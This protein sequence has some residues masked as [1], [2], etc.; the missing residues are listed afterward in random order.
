M[1]TQSARSGGSVVAR[2]TEPSA[3]NAFHGGVPFAREDV[4]RAIDPDPAR[5]EAEEDAPLVPLDEEV[6][7]VA[8]AAESQRGDAIVG[9]LFEAHDG[10]RIV[11][12]QSGVSSHGQGTY[13]RTGGGGRHIG[14]I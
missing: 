5:D 4:A 10:R 6:P 1:A 13:P 12:P 8:I 3:A 2:R 9:E 7:G 14:R 11:E